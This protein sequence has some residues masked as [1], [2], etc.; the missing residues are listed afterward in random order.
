ML[1]FKGT[2][3]PPFTMFNEPV[4]TGW[5]NPIMLN[6]PLMILVTVPLTVL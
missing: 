4:V 1:N 3:E 5:W 2:V 6:P